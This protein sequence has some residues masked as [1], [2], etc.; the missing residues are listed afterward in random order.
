MW[1]DVSLS[2][3][4][5]QSVQRQIK[6]EA[7]L[8]DLNKRNIVPLIRI[9]QNSKYKEGILQESN[10]HSCKRKGKVSQK[11]NFDSS[12]YSLDN[13]NITSIDQL[14]SVL[15]SITPTNPQNQPFQYI[16]GLAAYV[17][18]LDLKQAGLSV[19]EL[20]GRQQ[21]DSI[22]IRVIQPASIYYESLVNIFLL[23]VL[24]D[25]LSLEVFV[26]RVKTYFSTSWTPEMH[27]ATRFAFEIFDP[28]WRSVCSACESN[29]F[30]Q[31]QSFIV[32]SKQAL[33]DAWDERVCKKFCNLKS[34][35]AC[36]LSSNSVKQTVSRT[37]NM[38]NE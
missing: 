14:V 5:L 1:L 28:V 9:R 36:S 2:D 22:L 11:S 23:L 33:H 17:L 20:D 31:S 38:K 32:E 27:E 37:K 10:K 35:R 8:Q 25:L 7:C 13:L 26:D 15:D 24:I 29:R 4:V 18:Q 12:T 6:P 34:K 21:S 16:G 19:E 30:Q 3:Y